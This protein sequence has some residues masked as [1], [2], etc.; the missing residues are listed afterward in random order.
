MTTNT[1]IIQLT[2]KLVSFKTVEN[3]KSEMQA[4]AD[5]ILQYLKSD[6]IHLKHHIQ[7]GEHSIYASTKDTKT[8]SVLLV[9]HFDVV[10][11]PDDL[12]VAKIKDNKLIGRGVL[13]NKGPLAIMM[14]LLKELSKRENPPSIAIA[15]TGDE[16]IGGFNGIQYLLE[17][18]NIK[19]DFTIILDSGYLNEYVNKEKGLLFLRLKAKGKSSHGSRPW[20]GDN[21]IERLLKLINKIKPMFTPTRQDHWEKTLNLSMLQAGDAINKVPRSAMAKLDIRYTENEDPNK[22]LSE[23][24]QY[25]EEIGCI[26]V[27]TEAFAPTFLTDPNHFLVKALLDISE[28]ITNQEPIIKHNF[29]ASD[30]RH[31]T[32]KNLPCI[33]TYPAGGAH[34]S[35]HEYLELNKITQ[36]YEILKTFVIKNA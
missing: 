25:A 10:P 22:I 36:F 32:Q 9:A 34:H 24:K 3:N 28:Q 23:I 5:Y 13:D 2:K 31:F 35:D 33:Q 11:A 20:E 17:H 19:P 1:E 4:C 7:N 6:H 12:F 29:G 18:Q 27:E 15:T 16:E 8:P 21:A 14:V 26:E 30:A